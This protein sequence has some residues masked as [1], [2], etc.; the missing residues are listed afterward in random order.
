M[1][2][3]YHYNNRVFLFVATQQLVRAIKEKG[4]LR[5]ALTKGGKTWSEPSE[6]YP[7]PSRPRIVHQSSKR[8]K[9]VDSEEIDE[10]AEI[11]DG[12]ITTETKKTVYR[13]GY[14]AR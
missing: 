11:K 7:D 4:D 3:S 5:L 14:S 9:V 10:H 2:L 12:K 8:K 1:L 6:E 13:C